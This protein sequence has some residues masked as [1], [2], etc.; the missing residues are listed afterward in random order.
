[1]SLLHETIAS[2]HPIDAQLAEHVENTFSA[3]ESMNFGRFKHAL[4]RYICT[5]GVLHPKQPQTTIVIS[6]ADHGVAAESVSAYPPETTLH[7]MRNYLIAHGGAANAMANYAGAAL[8]V[9]DLG[10]NA[11]TSG[12]PGLL[13]RSIARGTANMTH[14]AAMTHEQAIQAVETGISIAYRCAE[15]GDSCILPG[16]MG[17]ANTTASAAIVA[18]FLEL[19]PKEV[20]GRGANISDAR[21][22]HKIETVQ[23]VLSINHPNP[24]DGLDVL[25]KVGGFELGCIAGLILGAAA[26][27]ILVILDG[28]NTTS[29]ALIA[30]SLAPCC[31]DYLLASHQSLTEGSQPHALRH[32]GLSPSLRLDIRL[33]ETAGSAIMLHMLTQMLCV[34]NAMDSSKKDIPGKR[35]SKDK[36]FTPPPVITSLPDEIQHAADAYAKT[37][38]SPDQN[39][40][41]ACQYHL[42]NLAKPI[43]SLGYLETI[44]VQLAGI[45]GTT[46][47]PITRTSALIIIASHNH[48]PEEVP[49]I[50][51]AMAAHEEMPI[52]QI[53]VSPAYTLAEGLQFAYEK[54]LLHAKRHPIILLSALAN[55]AHTGIVSALLGALSAA[56]ACGCLI[57]PADA[58]TD[59]ISREAEA[60]YP[61]L[62]P[63]ILHI[64]PDMLTP[65]AFLPMATAGILGTSIIHAA[66]H[67]LNDMKTFTETGVA[68]AID[69]LGTGR[70]VNTLSQ[71]KA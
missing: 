41:T 53:P 33:S 67:M 1:M 50:L 30:Q 7:M 3:Y 46:H 43:H 21:L 45:T 42:D 20:T 23:R 18:A 36:D 59:R 28:A 6:C 15:R 16:E 19:S 35:V 57:L 13:H 55:D 14:G 22:Q 40:M 64:L 5:Q 26:R 52:Y 34:W 51:S 44:A 66:L 39:A 17:I 11:D 68:V 60:S 38:P 9:A 48:L 31:T 54:T 32:L 8:I 37:I 63:Y 2:I 69:G 25:A 49:V 65:G 70:Q 10:V 29:A 56:A 12:I 47:P 71:S 4:I 24:K 62:S 58:Q 61:A 27:H